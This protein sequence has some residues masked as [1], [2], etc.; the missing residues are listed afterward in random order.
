MLGYYF[1]GH[2]FTHYRPQ[3]QHWGL[4]PLDQLAPRTELIR[5]AGVVVQSRVQQTRRGRMGMV[6]L[7]DGSARVE[8]T[9]FSELFDQV[10][11]LLKE[12]RLLVVEGKATLDNFTQGVRLTAEQV[13]SLPQAQTRFARQVTLEVSHS[14]S[15]KTLALLKELKPSF[16]PGSCAFVLRYCRPEVEASLRLPDFQLDEA[17][18]DLF[19][20][21][22]GETAL[23][24][25]Y[26]NRPTN[27]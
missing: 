20:A 10:R 13:L 12:D 11:P 24:L 23:T 21:R 27:E 4:T 1:S 18:W 15:A 22:F 19:R 6:T 3:L 14:Q 26:G 8:I 9:I 7:D 17:L 16:Q 2:P 5:V 25:D